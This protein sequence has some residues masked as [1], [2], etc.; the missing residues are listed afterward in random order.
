MI[1]TAH[2]LKTLAEGTSM[3]ADRVAPALYGTLGACVFLLRS[4]HKHIYMRDFDRR[5]KPEYVNRIVL[6]AISGAVIVLLV[7]PQSTISNAALGFLVGYNTD[8]LFSTI[9]RISNAIFPK[10]PD[11]SPTK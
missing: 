10:P 11:A 4:L 5:R 8:L 2:A 1:D 3:V 9:E 6:G 7:P